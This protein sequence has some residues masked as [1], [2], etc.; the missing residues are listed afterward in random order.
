MRPILA[1]LLFLASGAL[2]APALAQE[3]K[4]DPIDAA[5]SECLGKPEANSTAG[6][7]RCYVT[8]RDAWEAEVVRAY[9]ALSATL[10]G[11]SRGILR[12]AQK[13]WEAYMSA[14]RRFQAA[15]W[16][17]DRG[18]LIA[19]T[20]AA[21]NADLFKARALTLRNYKAD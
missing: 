11:R 1:G 16:T 3:S 17:S 8:T 6:M 10:D 7:V 12:G 21:Q 5:L 18:S 2:S 19:V 20:I 14:E 4:A 13:Q 9:A 15:P